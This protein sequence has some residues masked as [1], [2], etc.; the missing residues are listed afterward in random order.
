[1][2]LRTFAAFEDPPDP[3]P[4]PV[5]VISPTVESFPG[6]PAMLAFGGVPT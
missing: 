6:L 2:Q 3:P 5:D 1:M 4:P